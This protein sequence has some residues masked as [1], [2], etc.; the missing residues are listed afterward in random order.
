MFSFL[1][2][3]QSFFDLF[4]KQ[5]RNVNDGAVKLAELLKDFRDVEQRVQ[6]IKIIERSGDEIA[7]HT[8][9]DLNKTFITPLDREDIH[10]ITSRLDDV[11][12][13]VDT[14][15]SRLHLYRVDVI[16]SDAM[17]MGDVLVKATGLLLEAVGNLR[18][19]KKPAA[20]L[21]GCIDVHTQEH[22]GDRLSHHALA[23]LFGRNTPPE[24]IIKWKDIY[25]YQERAL[26]M[27]DD[28][29][30]VLQ[31]IVLKNN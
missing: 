22:E 16:T 19:L 11:L 21:Q 27:C 30:N 14:V 23:M 6:Q 8:F 31:T 2:K 29:A 10:E 28:V 12:D 15:A 4:E 13:S 20:I 9:D 18:N 3:D 26:D 5:A 24:D 7:R 25:Q 1:P 17:V